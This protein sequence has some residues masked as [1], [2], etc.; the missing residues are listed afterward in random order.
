MPGPQDFG[1]TPGL[2]K[3]TARDKGWLGIEDFADAAQPIIGQ[4]A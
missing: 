3:T 2:R 4:V 1:Y